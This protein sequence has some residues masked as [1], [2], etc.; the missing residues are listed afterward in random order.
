MIKPIY[1]KYNAIACTKIGYSP[2]SEFSSAWKEGY[3]SAQS[4]GPPNKDANRSYNSSAEFNSIDAQKAY[5]QRYYGGYN[6][7]TNFGNRSPPE[8]KNRE[9][10]TKKEVNSLSPKHQAFKNFYTTK[11][12]EWGTKKGYEIYKK[13]L[14]KLE[15]LKCRECM[16]EEQLKQLGYKGTQADLHNPRLQGIMRNLA[17]LRELQIDTQTKVECLEHRFGFCRPSSWSYD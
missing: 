12:S 8:E 9:S 5:S 16:Y 11:V 4:T 1:A 7:S 14:D 2:P 17:L 15:V 10:E 3:G 13:Q 6:T